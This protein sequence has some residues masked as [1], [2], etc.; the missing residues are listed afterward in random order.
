M[1]ESRSPR[2]HSRRLWPER[3]RGIGGL[4]EQIFD[5]FFTTKEI[6]QGTGLGLSTSLA[7]VKSH[8]GFIR[9]K[10]LMGRGTP[11]EVYLHAPAE[12]VTAAEA[13]KAVELS[14]GHGELILVVDDEIGVREITRRT[15]ENFGYRVLLAADGA[16]A[17]A[18]FAARR[19]EVAVV[20]TD[21]TMPS[22]GWH[23]DHP[24]PARDET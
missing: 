6:G 19:A 24:S 10:S 18:A 14:R 3:R 15:L 12:A 2:A 5:P 20:I 1:K 23:R 9:V 11:F 13:E 17:V 22:H 16:K 21:M 8:G 4:V 7:I